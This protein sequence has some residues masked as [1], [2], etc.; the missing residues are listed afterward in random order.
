MVSLFR[1]D[2]RFGDLNRAPSSPVYL[3]KEVCDYIRNAVS[4]GLAVFIC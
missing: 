2:N 3:V 4:E 1:I